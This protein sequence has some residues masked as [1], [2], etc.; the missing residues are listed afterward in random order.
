MSHDEPM[1]SKT[2]KFRNRGEAAHWS[3][4]QA[5]HANR[6]NWPAKRK[7]QPNLVSKLTAE[8]ADNDLIEYRQRA[9]R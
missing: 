6:F 1:P 5:A 8:L 9:S 7:A 2:P 4:M 3:R